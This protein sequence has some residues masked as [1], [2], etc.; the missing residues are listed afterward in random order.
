MAVLAAAMLA[1]AAATAQDN[2]GKKI[3]VTGSIQSDVLIPKEDE[4]INT[5]Q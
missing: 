2:G 1:T 3:T 5:T 4:K